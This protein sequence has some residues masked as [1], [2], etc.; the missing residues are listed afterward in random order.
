[1]KKEINPWVIILSAIILLGIIGSCQNTSSTSKYSGYSDTY[2]SSSTYR[3]NVSDISDIY[4]VS[5]KD[6][7]AKINAVTG[8]K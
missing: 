6:V 7:D 2:K 3:K 5:S 1:M 8:G 4:G